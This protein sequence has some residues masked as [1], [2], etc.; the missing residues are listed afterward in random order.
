MKRILI[1]VLS[2]NRT[3]WH[4]MMLKQQAT[5]DSVKNENTRTVFYVGAEE[6][7]YFDGEMLHSHNDESLESIGRRTVEALEWS[8]T[9]PWDFIA[10][11]HSST[12]MHKRRL[13]EFV[14]TL[15][16]A[17]VIYGLETPGPL[18]T[19]YLWGGGHYVLHRAA[20]E[21]LVA[22]KDQW[23]HRHMEDVSMSKLA[24]D[25]GIP[26]GKG[27][28]VGIDWKPDMQSA[29]CITYNGAKGGFD[30]TDFRALDAL[31]DQFFYRCKHD[32][33]RSMDLRTMDLLHQNLT[34]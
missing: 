28:S 3:P 17:P 9:Q 30:F 25:I 34:Q 15:P 19:P 24:Q 18:E 11:P 21:A 14:E 13:C 32:P 20:V 23:N 1:L 7:A 16:D 22:N 33:D 6:H 27:R 29:S 4:A 8:L 12:Y 2:A 26:F 5:W 31:D 10:R